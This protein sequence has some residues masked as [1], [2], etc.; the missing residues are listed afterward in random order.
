MGNTIA[1]KLH[2]R[3]GEEVICDARSHIM[4][5]ELS[6]MAWF[7]GVIPRAVTTANGILSWQQI[8]AALR[9]RGPHNAPTTLIAL[10]NT[11]QYGAAALSIRW[12]R[13]TRFASRHM[14]A[15]CACTLMERASSTLRPQRANQSRELPASADTVMFCLSKGLGAPVGSV[16][17]GRA[18]DIAEA[19][20][21]R[22]RLGGGMRQAGILAAAGLIALE[23]SP[24]RLK[25]DHANARMLAERLARIPGI[26][27][28]P[29]EV[30]TNIV[31][32]DI[33][34]LGVDARTFSG[35]LKSS[36]VWAN[37]ISA[38]HMRMVTH[39]DA[40]REQCEW[41]AAVAAQAAEHLSAQAAAV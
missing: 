7:A 39:R 1:I 16:L 24:A 34:G 37:G 3:H 8:A 18:S 17:V 36:G 13:L 15:G 5:W 31:I 26:R 21:Y 9:P 20:L 41:A 32:F 4:D 25:E 33:S 27:I 6:M 40:T 14:S 38:T 28:A 22:K 11:P 30:T 10:E 29:D 23:D 19:R 35:V 12:T 2:T